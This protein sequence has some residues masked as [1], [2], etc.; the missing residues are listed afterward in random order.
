MNTNTHESE[1]K[2]RLA[3]LFFYSCAFVCI[4]GQVSFA[5]DA[6]PKVAVLPFGGDAGADERE[7]AVFSIR[8]KLD[9]Q[10]V[11]APIDGPTIKDLMANHAADLKTN[12]ARVIDWTSDEAPDVIIWGELGATLSVHV[13][14]AR[15]KSTKDFSADMP[16]PT[17]M[18]FV[19]EQLIGVL[20]GSKPFDHPNEVVVRNDPA[21]DKLWKDGPN[22][23]IE[24]TFDAPGD[25]KAIL[26]SDV[27]SPAVTDAAPDV[28][29]VVIHRE[30]KQRYLAMKLSKDVAESNGLACLGGKIPVQ[31][32]TR[33]R[34][35]FRYRS[36][37]PTIHPFIKGYVAT[38]GNTDQGATGEREIYR[39]QVP[40][41]GATKGQWVTVV[42][43]MNPQHPS[44]TVQYLRVDLY[45]Y[46]APGTVEFDDVVIKAVGQQ[47][48]H[49]A[50]DALGN[51]GKQVR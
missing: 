45:A 51:T 20:P 49:A 7:R 23:C 21:A 14:D 27:Y 3:I 5:D 36:D 28:D 34:I 32:N 39:R 26:R 48:H 33:Y 50:D 11:Y 6:K 13:Y 47:T 37:G 22:L 41:M 31:P 17:R 38:P 18:R 35:S 30:G 9:R 16:D 1:K 40:P 19:T 2:R 4:R 44:L 12:A 46:F 43:E 25:W 29:Q 24:G 10:G 8:Q 15:D 42:D